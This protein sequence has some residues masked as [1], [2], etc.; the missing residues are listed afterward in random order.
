MNIPCTWIEK[1]S[2]IKILILPNIIYI[3]NEWN[4]IQNFSKYFVDIDKLL[5]HEPAKDPE[6]P[7]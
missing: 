2:I 3:F 6:E 1:R 7:T 5:L 4:L